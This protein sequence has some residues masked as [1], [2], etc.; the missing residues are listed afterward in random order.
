MAPN[1]GA[2][3]LL[4]SSS[5]LSSSSSSSNLR[6]GEAQELED[7]DEDD[8]EHEKRRIGLLPGLGATLHDKGAVDFPRG[9]G[10]SWAVGKSRLSTPV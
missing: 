7:D 6:A 1:P 4:E 3:R 9:V 5:S 2:G 10:Y 8:D